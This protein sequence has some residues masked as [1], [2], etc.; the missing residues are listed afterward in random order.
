MQ[1]FGNIDMQMGKIWSMNEF[2]GKLYAIVWDN[3]DMQVIINEGK[4]IN[5]WVCLK[6]ICKWLLLMNAGKLIK[7]SFF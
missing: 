6:F 5:E 1:L 7:Q 3:I 2:V 4:L